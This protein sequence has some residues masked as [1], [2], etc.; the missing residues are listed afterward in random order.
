MKMSIT[1][2]KHN[3][4]VDNRIRKLAFSARFAQKHRPL[5]KMIVSAISAQTR[6]EWWWLIESRM[7]LA[8]KNGGRHPGG[9]TYINHAAWFEENN[10]QATFD[11]KV[12]GWE[13]END[14]DAVLFK[15]R[16]G[17]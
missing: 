13:F 1:S 5:P 9:Q 4:G 2:L 14:E 7:K 6:N 17:L 10:I 12:C 3:I 16:F 8:V 15:L 11:F